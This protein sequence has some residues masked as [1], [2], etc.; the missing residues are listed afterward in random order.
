[1]SQPSHSATVS[2]RR[3]TVSPRA[4]ATRTSA[5]AVPVAPCIS[6]QTSSGLPAAL[7]FGPSDVRG[8]TNSAAAAAAAAAESL[9]SRVGAFANRQPVVV[10]CPHCHQQVNIPPASTN[11]FACGHCGGHMNVHEHPGQTGQ[12]AQSSE[13]PGQRAP[14]P[15]PA[16][17][18]IRC[19]LEDIHTGVTKRLRIHRI[20]A[21]ATAGER[22]PHTIEVVIQPG[23]KEGTKMTFKGHGDH[24]PGRAPQ[25]IVL[26]LREKP[27]ERFKR[28]G[29]D[30]LAE[31]S[32]DPA[33]SGSTTIRGVDGRTVVVPIPEL[34]RHKSQVSIPGAGLPERRNGALTGCRGALRVVFNLETRC[35][36]AHMLGSTRVAG[37]LM[38]CHTRLHR[39]SEADT[40]CF[41]SHLCAQCRGDG[42]GGGGR[43]GARTRRMDGQRPCWWR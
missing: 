43:N 39:S 30:L 14:G 24:F 8:F 33:Q 15:A 23:M 34:V 29:A 7:M 38:Q 35:A 11:V 28:S 36:S 18:D 31:L 27:H 32:L 41:M 22:T 10:Q 12:P 4:R 25:D 13:P 19:S 16:M 20:E 6:A 3:V 2:N 9:N 1:M 42:S 21:G 17:H 5:F 40:L 37:C 26:T